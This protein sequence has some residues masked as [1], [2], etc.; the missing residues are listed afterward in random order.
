MLT[1]SRKSSRIDLPDT[2]LEAMSCFLEY[3]YTG[4]Y[5]PAKLP[6]GVLASDASTP[7]IDESGAQLLKHAKVYT[8]A[9]KLGVTVRLLSP[10]LP[11]SPSLSLSSPLPSP[12]HQHPIPN[13]STEPHLTSLH[14]NPG[15]EIP[16]P[17][18]NPPGHL[19]RLGRTHLR[20]LR[21]QPHRAHR[22][23]D[24]AARGLLLGPALARAAARDR[25]H[26]PRNVS[27]VPGVCV[28]CAELCARCRGEADEGAEAGG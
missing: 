26:F 28:R 17:L 25:G 5:F 23:H 27:R 19:L 11:L 7:A 15:P 12:P 22:H 10:S 2:D 20:A 9:E 6:N 16:L 3:L 13:P 1:L 18:Q 21:L 14:K 24:P 8:L 4:E